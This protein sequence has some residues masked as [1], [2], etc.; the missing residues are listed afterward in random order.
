MSLLFKEASLM[1][2]YEALADKTALSPKSIGFST[3]TVTKSDCGGVRSS[4]LDSIGIRHDIVFPHGLKEF[5]K[6]CVFR[7]F[8]VIEDFKNVFSIDSRYIFLCKLT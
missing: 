8:L 2:S 1:S 7:Y 6:F 5:L 3:L 4:K